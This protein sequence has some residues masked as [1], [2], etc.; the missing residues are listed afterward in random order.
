MELKFY[1]F[2]SGLKRGLFVCLNSVFSMSDA[3]QYQCSVV[4]SISNW[5][6]RGKNASMK[7]KR[8]LEPRCHLQILVGHVAPFPSSYVSALNNLTFRNIWINILIYLWLKRQVASILQ[9]TLKKLGVRRP[10]CTIN[11]LINIVSLQFNL[12]NELHNVNIFMQICRHV[13]KVIVSL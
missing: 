10:T 4:R 5:G 9:N 7:E 13:E 6:E 11:M 8:A 1:V 3:V 2:Y 12:G